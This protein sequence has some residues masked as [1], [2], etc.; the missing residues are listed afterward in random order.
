MG[1]GCEEKW[2][3]LGHWGL[4]AIH[5]AM[6]PV[7]RSLQL[8]CELTLMLLARFTLHSLAQACFPS[9]Q[10]GLGFDRLHYL[11]P[12][13]DS[14]RLR[15]LVHYCWLAP[16]LGIELDVQLGCNLRLELWRRSL[17]SCCLFSHLFWYYK[18]LS[19]QFLLVIKL[20]KH[21]QLWYVTLL[22]L[23]LVL[24]WFRTCKN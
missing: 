22:K 14:F 19:R 10:D 12:L 5:H 13:L 8:S 17:Q 1:L 9:L 7:V 16:R 15:C 11:R 2:H 21:R 24:W 20:L 18:L 3:H 23:F 6:M 4:L